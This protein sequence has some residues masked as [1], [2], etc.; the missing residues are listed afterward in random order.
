VRR[1][2][3]SRLDKGYPETK[4]HLKTSET[5]TNVEMPKKSKRNFQKKKTGPR[6]RE[7]SSPRGPPQ[8]LVGRKVNG[9][10]RYYMNAAQTDTITGKNLLNWVAMAATTTTSYRMFSAIKIKSFELWGSTTISTSSGVGVIEPSLTFE[11]YGVSSANSF[12]NSSKY[13]STS[14][15]DRPAHLLMRP[16]KGSSQSMWISSGGMFD[17]TDTI[18]AIS[19]PIGAVIEYRFQACMSEDDTV[20]GAEAPVAATVGRVYYD[21]LDGRTSGNI[22]P[23]GNVVVPTPWGPEQKCEL[24]TF[25]H[26][27]LDITKKMIKSIERGKPEKAENIYKIVAPSLVQEKKKRISWASLADEQTESEPEDLDSY[28]KRL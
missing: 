9:C 26:F 5:V 28:I 21:Y 8:R 14:E 17:T 4:T 1:V 20:F 19:G 6:R 2:K 10:M 7:R 15:P 24:G 16:P 23:I 25:V 22:I 13:E 18:I 12:N 3:Y 11:W 27:P